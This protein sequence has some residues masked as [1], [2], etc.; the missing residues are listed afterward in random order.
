[1]H[2]KEDENKEKV[3]A[4]SICLLVIFRKSTSRGRYGVG[5]EAESNCK[6]FRPC[7]RNGV[8]R[9]GHSGSSHPR[10]SRSPLP[11]SL[12]RTALVPNSNISPVCHGVKKFGK[13]WVK[14]RNTAGSGGNA[15]SVDGRSQEAGCLYGVRRRNQYKRNEW[16]PGPC[17]GNLSMKENEWPG[18]EA[19][20]KGEAREA[21]LGGRSGEVRALT[22][23]SPNPWG[24]RQRMREGWG[25]LRGMEEAEK[26]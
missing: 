24:I 9:C 3:S 17:G 15:M 7:A 12:V 18:E 10:D 2:V 21:I 14:D 23:A 4:L 11:I 19:G 6:H 25:V 8:G 22:S 13:L 1:M 20:G 26:L 16:I 5:W